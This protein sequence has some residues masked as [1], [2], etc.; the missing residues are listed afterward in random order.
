MVPAQS[1][2]TPAPEITIYYVS[3]T[4][5][6]DN[7]PG[8]LEEPWRTIQH[9]ADVMLPGETAIVLPDSMAESSCPTAVNQEIYYI[10]R[11]RKTRYESCGLGCPHD[12]KN[13]VHT[14]AIQ[15]GMQ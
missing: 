7:N 2:P 4:N 1:T 12:P 8:T 3:S 14:Q 6:N 5:G 11:C 10:P 15:H 9:A 13:P